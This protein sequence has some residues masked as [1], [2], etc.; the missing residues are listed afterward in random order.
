[1]TRNQFVARD[2]ALAIEKWPTAVARARKRLVAVQVLLAAGAAFWLFA[3][4]AVLV[5]AEASGNVF[6]MGAS[7]VAVP[8][9]WAAGMLAANELWRDVAWAKNEMAWRLSGAL[10]GDTAPA[11]RLAAWAYLPV[12]LKNLDETPAGL[13]HWE[14]LGDS[15]DLDAVAV[16]VALTIAT[17]HGGTARDALN[18]AVAAY[19]RRVA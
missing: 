6:A 15:L 13:L 19:G 1:M 9:L 17:G 18:A 3:G 8:C 2:A 14:R 12:A 7:V 10:A 4:S 16:A 11:A 5:T